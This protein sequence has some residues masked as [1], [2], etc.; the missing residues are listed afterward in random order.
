MSD[1]FIL[2]ARER[3]HERISSIGQDSAYVGGH[4]DAFITRESSFNFHEYQS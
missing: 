4:P 1:S 3:G 2:P